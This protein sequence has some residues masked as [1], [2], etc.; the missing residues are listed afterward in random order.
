MHEESMAT[1]ISPSCACVQLC[2]WPIFTDNDD[3][4]MK[5]RFTV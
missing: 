3:S 4:F 5:V 2:K 1:L